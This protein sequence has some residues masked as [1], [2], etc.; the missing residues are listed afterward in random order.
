M[1]IHTSLICW[2][3]KYTI[4]PYHVG[5][6]GPHG[7]LVITPPKEHSELLPIWQE[8]I[9]FFLSKHMIFFVQIFGIFRHNLYCCD[10]YRL[11]KGDFLTKVKNDQ[12]KTNWKIMSTSRGMRHATMG[13]TN[14]P[15]QTWCLRTYKG[16]AT[17]HTLSHLAHQHLDD[18]VS[19]SSIFCNSFFRSFA[20]CQ[21]V[22]STPKFF[23][24]KRYSILHSRPTITFLSARISSGSLLLDGL[25]LTTPLVG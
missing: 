7:P 16:V 10:P 1:N 13:L 6:L 25:A 2:A 14:D 12:N 19:W 15:G 17:R 22:S 3:K 5:G 9:W 24:S 4:G 11:N 8:G 23:H 18:M 20:I 21:L